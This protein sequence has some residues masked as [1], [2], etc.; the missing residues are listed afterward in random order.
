M[1]LLRRLAT[2]LALGSLLSCNG[3]DS[4]SAP[5]PPRATSVSLSAS[6]FTLDALGATQQ[7]T[8]TVRDQFG[9]TMQG[10]PVTWSVADQSIATVS[11]TGLVTSVANG[12]TSV[13]A[14]S[15]DLTAT[16]TVTIQ[17]VATSITLDSNEL[18]LT[19]LGETAQ[20]TAQVLDR[21]GVPL[22]TATVAWAS[23]DEAVTT[24]SAT[25]L[26]TAVANGS[27]DVSA[28]L[29]ELSSAAAVTVAQAVAVITI[30]PASVLFDAVGQTLQLSATTTDV[31]GAPVDG[32]PVEWTVEDAAVATVDE[33]G[34][35]TAVA[36]GS[37]SVVAVSGEATVSVE[38]TVRIPVVLETLEL[39]VG[40][41]SGSYDAALTASGG[42]GTYEWAVTAGVLPPGLSVVASVPA[43]QGTPTA[44]GQ[45]N[46]TLTVTSDGQSVSGNLSITI[47]A[48]G[49]PV[50]ISAGVLPGATV[51]AP[52]ATTLHASGGNGTYVWTLA[53]DVLPPGLLLSSAGVL[54][55]T[56]THSG[57]AVFE[58]RA[59]SGNQQSTATVSLQTGIVASPAA[60][61]IWVTAP[62]S[63]VPSSAFSLTLNSSG[64]GPGPD[65]AGAIAI[66]LAWDPAVISM[67]SWDDVS[68]AYYWTG[69]RSPTVGWLRIVV[70]EEDGIPAVGSLVQIPLRSL[71]AAGNASI[72]ISMLQSVSI[73][74]FSEIDG[75]YDPV[76]VVVPIR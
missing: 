39:P 9:G 53:A 19:S 33:T 27:A 55:G 24:V 21:L 29:G 67:G 13:T 41:V 69:L 56:P 6:S 36:H 18:T 7:L 16:A 58:V 30:E 32:A 50:T 31:G 17:Q 60:P 75:Q 22:A 48:L 63:V 34:L 59:V 15:G 14:S 42:N 12:S 49:G 51:G 23:S 40:T 61:T 46:F 43:I 35:V 5:D 68:S 4:P 74:S 64:P 47:I 45:F 26:I 2:L 3:D 52:Y 66:E 37:T 65:P 71:G 54:S 10:A 28:T 8:A 70:A 44:S 11:A 76:S 25:G 1:N 57:A 72:T 20:L 38:V 62:N 73:L